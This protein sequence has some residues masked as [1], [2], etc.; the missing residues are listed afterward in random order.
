[1]TRCSALHFS[2]SWLS[3]SNSSSSSSSTS[4]S[5]YST[6][7][8]FFFHALEHHLPAAAP[9]TNERDAFWQKQIVSCVCMCF[10]SREHFSITKRSQIILNASIVPK[11]PLKP[12][13][14]KA[15]NMLGLQEASSH[16]HA[17]RHRT[18]TS[19]A[20]S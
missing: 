14:H 20:H 12:P 10:A 7:P 6:G 2:A 8:A 16:A 13:R 15:C 17:R 19:H 1:M 3:S 5:N 18:P 9:A 4:G 11:Q